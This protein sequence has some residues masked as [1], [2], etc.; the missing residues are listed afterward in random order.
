MCDMLLLQGDETNAV[1]RD[2]G[3]GER[4]INDQRFRRESDEELKV[5]KYGT[6]MYDINLW[7]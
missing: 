7:Y 2:S 3:D 1:D 4:E 6:T 5:R